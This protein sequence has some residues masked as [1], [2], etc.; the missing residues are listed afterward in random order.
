[1]NSPLLLVFTHVLSILVGKCCLDRRDE[2]LPSPGVPLLLE[3]PVL[4]TAIRPRSEVM[5]IN[6]ED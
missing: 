4:I 2:I 6:Y 3:R 1:M 5:F